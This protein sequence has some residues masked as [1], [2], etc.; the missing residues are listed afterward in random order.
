MGLFDFVKDIGKSVVGGAIDLGTSWVSNELI[1]KPNQKEAYRLA[2]KNSAKAFARSMEGYRQRIPYTVAGLRDA[3]LNPILAA[4]GGFNAGNSA[5]SQVGVPAIPTRYDHSATAAAR[6]QATAEKALAESQRVP[7]EIDQIRQNIKQSMQKVVNMRSEQRL[8]Q[9]N[10]RES[11]NRAFKL[12]QEFT[13]IGKQMDKMISEVNLLRQKTNREQQET[14][15]LILLQHQIK[16]ETNLLRKKAKALHHQM[17][18]L[19][20][21]DKVYQGPMGQTIA[22]I[23]AISGQLGLGAFINVLPYRKLR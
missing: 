4:S 6:N 22:Y 21:I 16:Q 2:D 20:K 7:H 15:R 23:N 5:T 18:R 12:E 3:G 11:I 14:Q 9:A 10:E 19:R 8:I 17:S 1:G 13:M